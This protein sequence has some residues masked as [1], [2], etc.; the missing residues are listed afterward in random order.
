M[1]SIALL[2]AT[3]GVALLT[4][5]SMV[6][7][8]LFD[9]EVS[10]AGVA[11]SRVAGAAL[12]GLAVACWPRR[13]GEATPQAL[14]GMLV[15]SLLATAILVVLGLGAHVAGKLLWPA[16]VAH[17]AITIWLLAAMRASRTSG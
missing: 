13:T 5:P 9:S 4:H 17:L 3:T 7:F 6:T 16:V 2:E 1:K 8:A 15:Y 14:R 12:V 10:G 11:A